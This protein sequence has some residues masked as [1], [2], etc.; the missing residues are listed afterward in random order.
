MREAKEI[1]CDGLSGKSG[2]FLD[3]ARFQDHD[4]WN[5]STHVATIAS[6]E[7]SDVRELG[8]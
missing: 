2:I 7:I 8:P 6:A 1:L 5:S 4:V 3:V